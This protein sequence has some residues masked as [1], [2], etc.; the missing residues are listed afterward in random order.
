MK[1]AVPIPTCPRG[2]FD[3]YA[4]KEWERQIDNFDRNIRRKNAAF[5]EHVVR[6][7]HLAV[8]LISFDK[9]LPLPLLNVLGPTTT[10][11][12]KSRRRFRF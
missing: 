12:T 8:A 9:H 11:K 10:V 1:K 6:I 7:D 4:R 5:R 3:P 2:K